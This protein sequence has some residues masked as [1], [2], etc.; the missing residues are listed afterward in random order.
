MIAPKLRAWL[1]EGLLPVAFL[2]TLYTMFSMRTWSV[3]GCI[4]TGA[5]DHFMDLRSYGHFLLRPV[6]F[7]WATLGRAFGLDRPDQTYQWLR[8]LF[9]GFGVVA[10]AAMFLLALRR[11]GSHLAAWLVLVAIALSRN[12]LR[13]F[14]TLDEKGLGLCLLALAL[15]AT[16]ALFGRI[17]RGEAMRPMGGLFWL[18][19]TLWVMAAFGHLQ[20]LPYAIAFFAGLIFYVPLPMNFAKRWVL[21]ALA[22]FYMAFISVVIFSVL[23]FQLGGLGAFVDF[24]GKLF[25]NNPTPEPESVRSLLS[26]ALE[27]Y[28]KAFFG[29]DRFSAKPYLG[30][31]VAGFGLLVVAVFWGFT[32]QRDSLAKMLLGGGLLHMALMPLAN[33]FPNYGDSYTAL[34]LAAMVLMTTAPRGLLAAVALLS[35]AVNLPAQARLS[36]TGLTM[37]QHL[38]TMERVQL[39]NG[40]APWVVV[41]E[42]ALMTVPGNEQEFAPI[43]YPMAPVL[44]YEKVT[45]ENLP[46]GRCLVE[47]P[48]LIERDGKVNPVRAEAID[49]LLRSTGREA[50]RYSL[51]DSLRVLPSDHR[52]YGTYFIL[53]A[54]PARAV[55]ADQAGFPSDPRSNP[56]QAS[57]SGEPEP[58][59]LQLPT[60]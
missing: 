6:A 1:L 29:V 36:W 23:H 30:L 15:V 34:I 33:A 14:A 43:Y 11:S 16:A 40:K 25:A 13:H 20:S 4:L 3:D 12:A 45:L 32:R 49:Q 56:P 39:Q 50:T 22:L 59:V 8:L 7:L 52:A 35:V 60:K 53:E 57:L 28:I 54:V 58:L 26:G 37:K 18:S 17:D 38:E 51:Y 2:V 44:V 31:A 46:R 55:Q 47:M 21:A 19:C 10:L 42:L 41:D 27:G 5:T 24:F 48:L 9:T